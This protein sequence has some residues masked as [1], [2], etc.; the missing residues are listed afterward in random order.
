MV[1]TAL[2][3]LPAITLV[4]FITLPA[5]GGELKIDPQ[6]L[7]TINY[8]DNLSL[9][10]EDLDIDAALYAVA[11]L[12]V[13]IEQQS[14]DTRLF[15]RPNIKQIE[16][17]ESQFEDLNATDYLLNGKIDRQMRRGT[18]GLSFS[19]VNQSILSSE[20]SD[21]EDPDPASS[22][23]FLQ[24]DNRVENLSVQ[25]YASWALSQA[26]IVRFSGNFTHADYTKKYGP[27]ADYTTFGGSI[28]YRHA[29]DMRNFI[30]LEFSGY[31]TDSVDRGRI[32]ALASALSP[33]PKSCVGRTGFLP[34]FGSYPGEWLITTI[35]DE[36]EFESYSGFLTYEYDISETLSV[37]AKYG[38]QKTDVYELRK[39]WNRL[40]RVFNSDPTFVTIS[41][42]VNSNIDNSTYLFSIDYQR[43]ASSWFIELTREVV[44]SSGGNPRDKTQVR[45]I[46]DYEITPATSAKI[47][48]IFY[49]Q[50]Q[51]N[52]LIRAKN[53]FLRADV[54][55]TWR[56]SRKLK[57]SASYI[58]RYSEPILDNGISPSVQGSSRQSNNLLTTV[59]YSF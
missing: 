10:S 52:A 15:L 51:Q 13:E 39:S 17:A 37:S 49:R 14:A 46:V 23:N 28:N 54:T 30:G 31:R 29:L 42:P 34:F 58:Y 47:G 26:D 11:S 27:Q 9:L 18:F 38:L 41:S 8:N 5:L 16:F 19:F 45:A 48:A 43:P 32:C 40:N 44:P 36:R 2:L 12:S 35:I 6:L 3:R 4:F 56:L 57:A 25:P 59:S 55:F 50:E 33:D 53:K 24:R 21:P 1:L 22:A 7:T 20:D